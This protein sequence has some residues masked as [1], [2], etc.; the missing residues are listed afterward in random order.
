MMLLAPEWLVLLVPV[1]VLALAYVVVQRRRPRYVVRFTTLDLLDSVAPRQPG[2]RRHLPSALLLLALASLVLALARP[3][4]QVETL[5]TNATVVLTVGA[6]PN[7]L[8]EDIE[9][10][11][12]DA[13]VH[14]VDT[15]L[16]DLPA[17]VEVGLVSFAEDAR[18]EAAPTTDRAA[19]RTALANVEIRSYTLADEALLTSLHVTETAAS[20][21]DAREERDARIVMLAGYIPNP[22]RRLAAAAERVA[23]AGIQ[24]DTIA[25]GTS[26]GQVLLADGMTDVP[27][28]EYE[29]KLIAEATGGTFY[30]APSAE[31]IRAVYRTIADSV[32]PVEETRELAGWLVAAA[33]VL[34]SLA[35]TCSLRW[36]SRFP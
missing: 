27:V 7:L 35:G 20:T 9:P 13:L 25:F 30:E 34:A 10:S 24:V 32:R 4:Q 17:G 3:V 31:A 16:D 11:R 8:A 28:G 21:L 12:F 36:F 5:E 23:Q 18:V 22:E 15:F 1:L 33:L 19:V 14:A 2:W 26:E 6:S 29:L